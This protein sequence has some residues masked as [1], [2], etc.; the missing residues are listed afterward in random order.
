VSPPDQHGF[1]SLGVSVDIV[2]GAVDTC[3]IIL[4]E[5][6]PNMPRTLGDSFL[7]VDR[8]AHLVP[9][10]DPL[11]ELK[12][13]PLDEVAGRSGITLPARPRRGD[14]ADGNRAHPDAV[15]AA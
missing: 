11:Y 6:N 4:A 5:V 8:I 7:H 12:S 1:V 13:E 15:M 9:V 2:R 3:D 14:P 10:D